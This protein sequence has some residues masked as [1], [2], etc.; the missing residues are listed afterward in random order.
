M[1][2]HVKSAGESSALVQSA[3]TGGDTGGRFSQVLL[4]A[5]PVSRS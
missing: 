2:P 4:H 3:Q 1:I 5:E